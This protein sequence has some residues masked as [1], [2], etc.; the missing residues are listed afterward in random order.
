MGK[1]SFSISLDQS[2]APASQVFNLPSLVFC[3]KAGST[4]LGFS[5]PLADSAVFPS[6]V[7][8]YVWL[9]F[10]D[11]GE[12]LADY[13]FVC[14]CSFGYHASCIKCSVLLRSQMLLSSARNINFAPANPDQTADTISFHVQVSIFVI[15]SWLLLLFVWLVK[16]LNWIF[17]R[18]SQAR[19]RYLTPARNNSKK[20]LLDTSRVVN[21]RRLI[22]LRALN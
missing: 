20:M 17:T 15:A 22:P 12:Q 3:T 19:F 8:D 7:K 10:S 1:H 11:S 2:S 6:E 16:P 18:L 9:N 14:G 4:T 5:G 21:K 13:G